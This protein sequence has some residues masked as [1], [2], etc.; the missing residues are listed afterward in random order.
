MVANTDLI[1][2]ESTSA[3][4]IHIINST[5][6][7]K[8]IPTT[9]FMEPEITG[10]SII[11]CPAF[12]F[13]IEHP[14]TD[15]KLLFDLGVRKDWENLPA[16]MTD[17]IK[18]GRWSVTV[19]KGV[20]DILKDGGVNLDSINAI[21]WSHFHWDHTGDPSTF[22]HSTDLV[23]GPGFKDALLPGYPANQD[24]PI[25]E[26]DYAGRTLREIS[27]DSG[28][29][30]GGY[31]ALD[32]FDDG[33]FYL[34]DS[35][36]HAVG[37]MCA[38]ARTST[39]PSTFIFLGGDCAHHCGQFRPSASLPLPST[40]S[41]SPLPH[42]HPTTCP[43]SLFIPI[44]RLYDPANRAHATDTP[45]SD[46]F[47][48]VSAQGAEDVTEARASI[49]KLSNFDGREDVL[50]MIA[51]D[52]H[53]LEIVR[54][55]PEGKANGWKE[56]GWKEKGMWRFLADLEP[57]VAEREEPYREYSY[58]NSSDIRDDIP[59]NI[60]RKGKPAINIL[61]YPRDINCIYAELLA[62]APELWSGKRSVYEPGSRSEKMLE[63]DLMIHIGM[64]PDDE[65]F[66]LET[67]ARRE[68]YEL[69]GDDGKYLNRDALKGLPERLG[70][71]FDIE[72][73]AAN[74]RRALPVD[75]SVKTSNDAGLYFCE[76]ISYLS[77]SILD[78]K[79]EFGRVVFLHV[80]KLKTAE[81]IERGVKVAVALITACVDSLPGDYKH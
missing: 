57:A 74:V 8:G 54:C 78:G 24:S 9:V 31:R 79:N 21:I 26:S 41:P 39:S 44:H 11:D 3:V 64:H 48:L 45:T 34:L 66:F 71:G 38:L 65:D 43:G 42:L 4:N 49:K 75:T 61:K 60:T 10:H 56:A 14:S 73:V 23:V 40:L 80:P 29:Q 35:P 7:I 63:I 72:H 51:H 1:I 50:V 69:P 76:L 13:L 81:T 2:P 17:R 6:R 27:F 20:A 46:P 77:L 33:S 25:R 18:E 67:R 12:S 68:R 22:P 16:R 70:V 59:T 58:N 47:Y 37:H 62:L 28:L 5:T 15:V 19:E 30:I 53:M 52:E 36:G 32:Y 55:F